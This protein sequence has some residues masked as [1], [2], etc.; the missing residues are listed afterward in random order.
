MFFEGF[1][2]NPSAFY[3]NAQAFVLSS[4]FEGF[5][6]VIVEALS[7]GLPVVS[8]DCMGG[9]NYIL[10]SESYGELCAVNDP[11]ALSIS[12]LKVLS[13]L[14]E[15]SKKQIMDRSRDFDVDNIGHQY[16]KAITKNLS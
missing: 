14:P 13:R 3:E 11:E 2:E 6:N 4:A 16:L 10:N 5:G 7:F 1:V 15:Y 12:I 9:P 8:T